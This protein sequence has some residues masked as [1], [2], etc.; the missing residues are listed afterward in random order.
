VTADR[1]PIAVDVMGA[2]RGPAE[3]VK[4]AR[5]AAEEHG[6]PVVL[7]GQPEAIGDAG[8][9]DVLPASEVVEM[10]DDPVG[11]IRRKRD[12]SVVRAAE[13][14]RDG[15]ASAVVSAGNTGAAVASALLRVGRIAGVARP[16]IATV[17]PV[18]GSGSPNIL[19]D[20]GANAE[21]SPGWLAQFAQMGAV[22]ASA[23]FGVEQPRVGL[24]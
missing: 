10:G 22:Y 15:T 9:L 17:L 19:L 2:D 4:G 13:A 18:P 6:V 16:A 11:G 5:Q 12:A 1:L 23:R 21:C 7:V 3:I 8:G 24:V 14:V 20:A